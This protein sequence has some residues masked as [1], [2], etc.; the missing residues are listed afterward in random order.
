MP[1]AC[2]AYRGVDALATTQ[3]LLSLAGQLAAGFGFGMV[4]QM[5]IGPVSLAVMHK[6]SSE[7]WLAAWAMVWGV[8]LTDGFY[9]ALAALGVAALVQIPVLRLALGVGGPMVL[10]WLGVRTWRAPS[11]EPAPISLKRGLQASLAAGITVTLTN[12]LTVLFWS[13]VFGRLVLDGRFATPAALAAFGLGCVA[14]TLTALT[15]LSLLATQA[16]RFISPPVRRW[17]NRLT[18]F[19]LVIFACR[20]VLDLV[21]H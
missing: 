16:R 10:V 17:L 7:R 15:V 8:V 2:C 21:G 14:S 6:A 12:P 13:G 1:R 20:M 3:S 18:G 5:G 4:F 11:S 19:I 9:I